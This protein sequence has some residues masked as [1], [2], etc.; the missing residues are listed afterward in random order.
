M[1]TRRSRPSLRVRHRS[2]TLAEVR[3]ATVELIREKG[4]RQIT[5]KEIAERA[6]IGEATLF[7]H[8]KSK[9]ALL[10]GIYVER[11]RLVGAA[12]ADQMQ[13][14]RSSPA[15]DGQAAL[16]RVSAV[17]QALADLY[18]Q[19]PEHASFYIRE[20]FDPETACEGPIGQEAIAEGDKLVAIVAE[21]LAT[22][23][24]NRV[25]RG[26]IDMSLV[27]QNC[28]SIWV[29]EIERGPV[30]GFPAETFD[31]RVEARMQ[32]QLRPLLR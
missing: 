15:V 5:T 23:Q 8:V 11:V 26:D 32:A 24:Q 3:D 9:N 20:S 13:Q 27:A 6:Q 30:R 28:H 16:D 31:K 14:W 21:V 25:L 17:Y 10:L 22:A 4:L 12:L 1:E 18:R 29:H 7:R 19:D 2:Q